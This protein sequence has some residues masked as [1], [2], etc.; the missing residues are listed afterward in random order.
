ML[1]GR[2]SGELEPRVAAVWRGVA[3]E[4]H[5][6]EEIADEVSRYAQNDHNVQVTGVERKIF[7]N[8]GE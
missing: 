3:N 6:L 1:G 2:R 5:I 4:K 8:Y 7:S